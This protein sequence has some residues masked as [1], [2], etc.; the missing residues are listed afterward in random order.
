M[1]WYDCS[2]P[3]VSQSAVQALIAGDLLCMQAA[4]TLQRMNLDPDILRKLLNRRLF[5]AKDLLL[6]THLE[7][8][9]GLDISSEAVSNLFLIVSNAV[10]PCSSTVSCSQDCADAS[11]SGL[12]SRYLHA[13]YV[14][15]L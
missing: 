4:K 9:E 13:Y 11:R 14:L 12:C 1:S 2:D 5:S 3:S 7:L 8:V 6:A 15:D 10:A